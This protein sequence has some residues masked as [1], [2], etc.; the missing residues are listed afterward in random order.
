MSAFPRVLRGVCPLLHAASV[1]LSHWDRTQALTHAKQLLALPLESH[2]QPF[3]LCFLHET[4]SLHF[5]WAGLELLIL[6]PVSPEQLGLQA[7]TAMPGGKW[8]F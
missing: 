4:D 7:C 3:P 6:L 8:Y 5:S 2:P 1:C